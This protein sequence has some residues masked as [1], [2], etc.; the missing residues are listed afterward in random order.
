M[1]ARVMNIVFIG[2]TLLLTSEVLKM[3]ALIT[4]GETTFLIP[5][6]SSIFIFF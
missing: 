2:K 5:T 1:T 3:G 4:V 6:V